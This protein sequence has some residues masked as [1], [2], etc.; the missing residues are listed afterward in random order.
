MRNTGA[1]F[2]IFQNQNAILAFI[3][4]LALVVLY[5]ALRSQETYKG[6]ERTALVVFGAGIMGNLWDRVQY[7]YVI[8][9]IGVLS[10]TGFPVFNI[11]DSAISL[12]VAYLVAMSLRNTYAGWAFRSKLPTNKSQK[13][14]GK[15]FK[16]K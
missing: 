13:P 10:P 4:A 15:F 7:Q 1:G 16:K 2:G 14:S 3:A 11:A 12:S 5:F 9:F 8:D 6:H